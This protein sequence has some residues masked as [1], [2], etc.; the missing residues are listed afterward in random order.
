[1]KT[2]FHGGLP[3]GYRVVGTAPVGDI[4]QLAAAAD[5][6]ERM[7]TIAA[8]PPE[9]TPPE[10][11]VDARAKAARDHA[12]FPEA[13]REARAVREQFA[14]HF[15]EA[16]LLLGRWYR[17]VE[18]CDRIS[19]AVASKLPDGSLYYTPEIRAVLLELGEDPNPLPVLKDAGYRE[20]ETSRS[21]RRAAP[22]V[23]LEAKE[24]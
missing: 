7:A 10:A 1:M 21:W 20:V 5:A 15:R 22:L 13:V 18:E 8:L 11:L 9:P 16:A 23:A 6:A 2:I 17:L 3:E 19:S 24:K 12:R 14:A 4:R